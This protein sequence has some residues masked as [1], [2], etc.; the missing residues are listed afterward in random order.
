MYP[1]RS[2]QQRQ[3]GISTHSGA[4][5]GGACG[6]AHQSGPSQQIRNWQA[7]HQARLAFGENGFSDALFLQ[8]HI[9]GTPEALA[10]AAYRGELLG[11]TL[12][13]V[14]E[15]ANPGERWAS[16]IE[17]APAPLV[18]SLAQTLKALRWTGGGALSLMRDSAER[19][20]A[21]GWRAGFPSVD[22]RRRAG[23]AESPSAI[24]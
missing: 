4:D 20:W 10:F 16:R 3:I 23:G 9:E 7:F 8:E 24:A 21:L 1:R 12:C 22:I 13:T 17:E 2:S 19:R 18:E 14:E 5:T 11:C 15:T 6:C